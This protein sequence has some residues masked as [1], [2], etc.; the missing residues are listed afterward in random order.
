MS[1][2]PAPRRARACGG[3]GFIAQG[4]GSCGRGGLGTSSRIGRIY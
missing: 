1:W 4:G 3:V 2:L